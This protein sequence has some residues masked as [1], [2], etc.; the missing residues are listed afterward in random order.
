M[1]WNYI[2]SNLPVVSDKPEK[3]SFQDQGKFGREFDEGS[4]KFQILNMPIYNDNNIKYTFILPLLFS[5]KPGDENFMN[6]QFWNL[7]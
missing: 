6:N 4:G 1:S 5:F 2:K 7:D 3:I